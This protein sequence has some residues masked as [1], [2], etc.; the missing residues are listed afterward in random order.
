MK[1]KSIIRALEKEN[2]SVLI[3]EILY[4]Q[5]IGIKSNNIWITRYYAFNNDK[6]VIWE[7]MGLDDGNSEVKEIYAY[8]Q[9]KII[10]RYHKLPIAYCRYFK[11]I[12]KTLKFIKGELKC[13]I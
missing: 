9:D 1:V 7:I 2:F 12:K 6:L 5:D 8:Q 11:T 13:A 4:I 10:N 3:D